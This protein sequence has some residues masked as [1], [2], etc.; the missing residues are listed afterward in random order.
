MALQYHSATEFDMHG[1]IILARY[2]EEQVAQC[3]QLS[4]DYMAIV[5]R[6]AGVRTALCW[7]HK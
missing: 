7:C 2:W 3:S 6:L 1:N 5:I 4:F